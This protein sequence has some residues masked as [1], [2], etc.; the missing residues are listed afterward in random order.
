MAA[1]AIQAS[2]LACKAVR[3]GTT[4]MRILSFPSR[5]FLVRPDKRPLFANLSVPCLLLQGGDAST[6]DRIRRL[7][8]ENER[9]QLQT[10]VLSERIDVQVDKMGE[11]E[12]ALGDRKR[13][14]QQAE[15]QLQRVSVTTRS[16]VA[17][18]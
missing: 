17:T 14:L 7:Q 3:T 16:R 15:D 2:R 12:V 5:S 18:G 6:E 8:A 9:L 1:G 11:L 10:A 4:I 13:S